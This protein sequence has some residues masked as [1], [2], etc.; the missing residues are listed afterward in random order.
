MGMNFS[1]V[2]SPAPTCA[3]LR[4]GI[5][6]GQH[7]AQLRR[8]HVAAAGIPSAGKDREFQ[9]PFWGGYLRFDC[10]GVEEKRF[11]LSK[12]KYPPISEKFPEPMMS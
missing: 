6:T 5:I 4:A 10:Q 11:P 12:E 2:Y 3:P 7:P 1:L 9:E 8:T